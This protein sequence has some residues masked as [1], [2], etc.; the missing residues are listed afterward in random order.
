M[1]EKKQKQIGAF[2]IS[3]TM[4]FINNTHCVKSNIYLIKYNNR[5]TRKSCE[6]CLNLTTKTPEQRQQRRSGVFI[7][8]F[9]RI[10]HFF[11]VF[12]LLTL[13]K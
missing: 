12:L 7:G 1:S 9:K 2:I 3:K 10:S 13:N 11:I 6:I 4:C 8:N 5:N